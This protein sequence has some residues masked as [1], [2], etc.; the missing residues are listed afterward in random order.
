MKKSLPQFL[1]V[2]LAMVV[3]LWTAATSGEQ[4]AIQIGDPVSDGVPAAGAGR[5]AVSTETDIYT[6]SAVAGQSVFVEELG[7]ASTFAGWLRWELKAP[8]GAL[9]FA[10][11]LD[12]NNEGRRTLPETGTYTLRVWVGTANPAYV[13]TYAFRLRAI[14]ADQ[15]FQIQFGDTIANSA[16]AAGAGN[17][18]VAG[19]WDFYTFNASAGQLVFIEAISA[20]SSF[21]GYLSY[22]LKSPSSNLVASG[23][24]TA[25]AHPGRKT[26]PETGTYRMKVY[27][28]S[29]LTN[30][31]GT[32]SL[33]VR[34]IPP[35]QTFAIEPGDVITNN[36][37]A[38]GAGNIESPGAQDFYTF[39]G[40]AGQSVSFQGIS[41]SPTFGGYL[42]WEVKTPSGQSVFSAYFGDVG[43]KTLPETGTY[44]MRVWVGAN[45]TSYVGTYSFRL[46]TLPGDVRCAIE[47]GDVVSDGVPVA[48]AGRIDEPGGQDT[49]TFEG[50]AG[51]RVNFQQNSADPAFAGYLYWR[52]IAPS[53]SNW[54]GAYFPGGVTERRTLPE[55]GTYSIRVFANSA[56][57]TQVGPYSF[58]IWCDVVA[59]PDQFATTPNTPLP[60]PFAKFLCNDSLEIGDV[61]TV[62]TTAATSAKGGA[63]VV[64]SN[65]VIYAPPAG[66]NGVDN[67]TYRLRGQFGGESTASVSVTTGAGAD[68]YATV[69][70]LVREGPSSTMVCLLGAPN[71][72]YKIEQSPDLAAWFEAGSLTADEMGSLVYHYAFEPT[73]NRFYRFR[74]Q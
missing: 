16:P 15:T 71:Q 55:T 38:A 35:D 25:G 57:A 27:A 46:Y 61:P 24:L 29:F 42:Q 63:L 14:P 5:M 7:V 3:G 65:A 2:G 18:E 30:H 21:Q 69:V 1:R 39:A 47:K 33:R 67:F 12:N 40:T 68:R 6:F 64:T 58:R 45:I 66:F 17:L 4:F 23:Y 70:S 52:V 9:V 19:A 8:S 32:Y 31:M 13:G 72:T 51:Q 54:F 48:A 26:L 10:S 36:V 44:T 41:K 49:Y 62:D 22:E 37:P 43:R 60:I 20:A 73:G 56:V 74:R 34:G 59:R 28:L 11:Y 53:G 50:L